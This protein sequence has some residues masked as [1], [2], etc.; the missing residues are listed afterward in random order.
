M[1]TR[2]V[3]IN[4]LSIFRLVVENSVSS[5]FLHSP[6]DPALDLEWKTENQFIILYARTEKNWKKPNVISFFSL[7]AHIQQT[8]KHPEENVE[9]KTSG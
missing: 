1:G 3:G 9:N 5:P 2:E 8:H 7:F 6:W 4:T